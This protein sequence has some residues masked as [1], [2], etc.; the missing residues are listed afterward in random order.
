[1]A[2]ILYRGTIAPTQPPAV[3]GGSVAKNSPLTNDEGDWNY[4]ALNDDIQTRATSA[5]PSFTGITSFEYNLRSVL[6]KYNKYVAGGF[7]ATSASGHKIGEYLPSANNQTATI[8][9]DVVGRSNAIISSAKATI[10]IRSNVL[11]S[12]DVSTQVIYSRNNTTTIAIETWRDNSTGRIVFFLVP[13]SDLDSVSIKADVFERNAVNLFSL[14]TSAVARNVAGLTQV[15]N[16]ASKTEMGDLV[17]VSVSG[18]G[19]GLTDLN[20]SNIASGTLSGDRGVA[21]GSTS[22]S[23]V[24]YNGTTQA[25]GKF[26]SGTTDPTTNTRLNYNGDF[27]ATKFYGTGAT[28][29]D[30]VVSFVTYNT[31][32]AANGVFYGGPTVPSGTTRLNYGGYFYATKFYGDGSSL[33]N[34]TAD[35]ISAGTLPIGRGGTGGTTGAAAMVS[36]ERNRQSFLDNSS[37]NVTLSAGVVY[38]ARTGGGSFTVYLPNSP[39]I[40]D[41]IILMNLHNTWTD[42]NKV[43]VALNNPAH[44]M[45]GCAPGESLVLNT[46]KARSARF[47]YIWS[48]SWILEIG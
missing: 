5:N 3:A 17:T 29:G 35:N 27:Y 45:T 18:N 9:L 39:T 12:V 4:K 8:Y 14:S 13:G 26:D 22:K 32:V 6:A 2:N 16:I 34:I 25:A 48:N 15:V 7:G 23:F 19:S 43:T 20:A 46:N 36:L 30:N 21:A 41:E 28:A 1:M 10:A 47:R 24:A 37:H 33:T 11:P 31:T 38:S 40:G 42:T 44:F